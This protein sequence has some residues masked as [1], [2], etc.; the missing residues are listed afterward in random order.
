MRSGIPILL[1]ATLFAALGPAWLVAQDNQ[2][3]KLKYHHYQLIDVGTFGGPQ[4]FLSSGFDINTASGVRG[5]LVGWADTAMPDPYYPN[6]FTTD[7]YLGHAFRLQN[8]VRTDL[9][10]LVD[11]FNSAPDGGI[12]DGGLIRGTAPTGL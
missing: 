10:V 12:N 7:C 3:P 1:K 2:D 5:A 9:G 8:G 4:G 6:C 11:G